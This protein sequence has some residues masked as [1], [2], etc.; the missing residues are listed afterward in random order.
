MPN[1]KDLKNLFHNIA[2]KNLYVTTI[3]SSYF[4]SRETYKH[5]FNEDLKAT[6][7]TPSML[8]IFGRVWL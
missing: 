8:E 3:L 6:I 7:M 1:R 4:S 5:W 2:L